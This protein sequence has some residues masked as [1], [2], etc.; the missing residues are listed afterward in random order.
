MPYVHAYLQETVEVVHG[1][2]CKS[3]IEIFS[4]R[5]FD[6]CVPI[7][8]RRGGGGTVV[9]SP[10]MV[11][12]LIVGKRT[13]GLSIR[14]TYSQIHRP[15]ISLIKEATGLELQEMGISDLAVDNKK[16]L[17][18]S[19]YLTQNPFFY[20]YQSSLLVDPDCSL[21]EK[22]L[23]HPPREPDYRKGRPHHDFCISLKDLGSSLG[24]EEILSILNNKLRDKIA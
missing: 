16:I 9:L 15:I 8:K 14:D 24:S 22:Y 12:I 20:Y 11:I 13:K 10:G 6:D 3:E 7:V 17:G 5:C 21:I 4:R 18:S 1:P 19:L 23:K 2:S